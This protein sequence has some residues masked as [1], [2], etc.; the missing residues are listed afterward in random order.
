MYAHQTPDLSTTAFF[1]LLQ[2]F[3]IHLPSIWDLSF[4]PPAHPQVFCHQHSFTAYWC[5][6]PTE[7]CP[8][9]RPSSA[10]GWWWWFRALCGRNP[11]ILEQLCKIP[12]GAARLTGLGVVSWRLFIL[13]NK[14]IKKW[15][16]GCYGYT[17]TPIG[18]KGE[19]LE[20]LDQAL[21]GW[22]VSSGSGV[23]LHCS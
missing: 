2:I 18:V 21:L 13:Q 11:P 4:P 5:C 8:T 7:G 23:T 1:S 19:V 15:A 10:P 17:L 16:A 22:A 3:L 6:C 9:E 20:A 12:V 14:W